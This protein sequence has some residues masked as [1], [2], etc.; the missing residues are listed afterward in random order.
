MIFTGKSAQRLRVDLPIEDFV[1]EL[2]NYLQVKFNQGVKFE[3]EEFMDILFLNYEPPT[4]MV[5]LVRNLKDKGLSIYVISNNFISNRFNLKEMIK[6][7][8]NSYYSK[9]GEKEIF[10][11]GNLIM[12]NEIGFAKPNSLAFNKALEKINSGLKSSLNSDSILFL[13]DQWE[14]VNI[15]KQLG[16]NVVRLNEEVSG[17]LNFF[18]ANSRFFK[19][20]GAEAVLPG[21]LEDIWGWYEVL[22]SKSFRLD[23]IKLALVV[24]SSFFRKGG[25]IEALNEIIK[26]QPGHQVHIMLGIYGEGADKIRALFGDNSNIIT[27]KTA[28]EL[29]PELE[30]RARNLEEDVVVLKPI[31]GKVDLEAKQVG[32]SEKT[33]STV[34]VA[35]AMQVLLGANSEGKSYSGVILNRFKEFYENMKSQ[36]VISSATYENTKT[37]VFSGLDLPDLELTQDINDITK[38]D[39]DLISKFIDSFI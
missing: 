22:K 1:D 19:A 36:A 35:K 14:N 30:K 13:D 39:A 32:F 31:G 5:E 25:A 7:R 12:S 37:Q 34:A 10:N 21:Y 23:D 26:L 6:D 8:L 9:S 28:G 20:V 24:H 15:A 3:L 17:L 38:D 27:A 16:Y 18:D 29:K 11:D 33:I 2:N 4:G